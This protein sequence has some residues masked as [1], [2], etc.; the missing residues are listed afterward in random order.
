MYSDG[1]SKSLNILL[2]EIKLFSEEGGIIDQYTKN[3]Q[4]SIANKLTKVTKTVGKLM[5]IG[6]PIAGIVTY[7]NKSEDGRNWLKENTG[8]DYDKT[9][10]NLSDKWDQLTGN[11]ISKYIPQGSISGPVTVPP[12]EPTESPKSE[13]SK[14]EI[15]RGHETQLIPDTKMDDITPSS[16]VPNESVTESSEEDEEGDS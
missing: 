8:F 1:D 6:V 2:Q 13:D 4:R 16:S 14:D 15:S 3:M 9:K 10:D 12:I 7:L 11:D 5:A